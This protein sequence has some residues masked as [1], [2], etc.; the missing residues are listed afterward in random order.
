[1]RHSGAFQFS[2]HK[3]EHNRK[4]GAI[5]IIALFQVKRQQEEGRGPTVPPIVMYTM[6]I[7]IVIHSV[8]L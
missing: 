2:N 7:A 3:C 4:T 6:E 1:M 8:L 5:K